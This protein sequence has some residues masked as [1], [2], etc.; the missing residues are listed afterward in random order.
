M[1]K[2]TNTRTE[3]AEL[4]LE[5]NARQI[6]EAREKLEKDTAEKK[7]KYAA[8]M[9][10]LPEEEQAK[11]SPE[12]DR[13]K[14]ILYKT[15]MNNHLEKA[16]IEQELDARCLGAIALKAWITD[17]FLWVQLSS[18]EKAR[19][20]VVNGFNSTAF[21][22]NEVLEIYKTHYQYDPK[23]VKHY[24]AQIKAV[25]EMADLFPFLF[26]ELQKPIYCGKSPADLLREAEKDENGQPVKN[27]LYSKAVAAALKAYNKTLGINTTPPKDPTKDRAPILNYTVTGTEPVTREFWSKALSTSP[28]EIIK[29]TE[30]RGFWGY[31]TT[32]DKESNTVASVKIATKALLKSGY[33]KE[34]LDKF[35]T[36]FDKKA[37]EAVQ[38]YWQYFQN[39]IE[40][41]NYSIG[42]LISLSQLFHTMGNEG[43]PNARQLAKLKESLLTMHSIW[44]DVQAPA[45]ESRSYEAITGIKAPLLSFIF[46]TRNDGVE[47]IYLTSCPPLLACSKLLN[48]QYKTE[49]FSRIAIAKQGQRMSDN[50]III[51]DYLSM[52]I[53]RIKKGLEDRNKV[54]ANPATLLLSTMCEKCG[55]ELNHREKKKRAVQKVADILEYKKEQ[56]E[57]I[58][59][60]ISA[61]KERFFI[62]LPKPPKTAR[63]RAP[64]KK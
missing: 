57:I 22:F 1:A 62:E 2:E 6:K 45:C 47:C 52:E 9:Q 26:D 21:L 60:S 61:D 7:G 37:L 55:L 16:A 56:K 54:Q 28:L 39:Q 5:E 34:D 15:F 63:K 30:K 31:T 43:R 11:N 40:K 58:N 48:N 35:L 13:A 27:S 53:D 23:R 42:Q 64:R 38:A 44:V 46:A 50:R 18:D 41:G 4:D 32:L 17:P 59:F 3:A 12:F 8:F 36:P 25:K 24:E 29:E 20:Y 49:P 10:E 33:L 51:S 19:R 14:E